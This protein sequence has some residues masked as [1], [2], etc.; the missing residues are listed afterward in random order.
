MRI[1]NTRIFQ[2]LFLVSILLLVG[3]SSAKS[4]NEDYLIEIKTP[5]GDMKAILFEETPLHKANFI[6]LVEEGKY[7][8][9]LWHR[10][11]EGFMIQGG[12]VYGGNREPEGS[13]IPAEIVEGLYHVKGAIAAARQGNQINPEKKSSSC[14]FYIVHGEPYEVLTTDLYQLNNAFGELVNSDP[15]R[16]NDL[17]FKYQE[18]VTNNGQR[19]GINFI[20]SQRE[21]IESETNRDFGFALTPN[22]EKAY[23]EAGFGTNSLDGEYTVFGKVVEGLAVIDKIAKVPTGNANKPLEDIDMTISLKTV[24][25]SEITEKYGYSYSK[26]L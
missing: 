26:P 20:L 23:K 17:I 25:K 24:P 19:G 5:M 22:Q 14:Q 11:I 2:S 16:F 12:D 18:A 7:D 4:E 8:N 3:C 6:K 10:V 9:T 15:E 21:F 13:R 1:N